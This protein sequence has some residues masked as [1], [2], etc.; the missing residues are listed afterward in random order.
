MEAVHRAFAAFGAARQPAAGQ[1][2]AKKNV[3]YAL[4]TACLF[5]PAML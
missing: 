3:C 5:L 1:E 4:H 2:A